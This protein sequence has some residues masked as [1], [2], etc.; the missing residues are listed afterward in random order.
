MQQIVEQSLY[1]VVFNQGAD[2]RII[3]TP[4]TLCPYIAGSKERCAWVE[5][6]QH[7]HNY[8][9]SGVDSRWRYRGLPAIA[10]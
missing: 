5:G 1:A 2:A 3:G 4:I 6:W 9:G 7:V 10:G 8:W